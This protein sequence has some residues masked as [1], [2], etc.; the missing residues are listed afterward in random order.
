MAKKGQKHRKYTVEERE[1]IT[2]EYVSGKNQGYLSKKY[3]ISIGT[4]KTWKRKYRRDGHTIPNKK[5][6]PK[7]SHLSEIERLRLENDILKKFQVFLKAQQE[8]K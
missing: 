1:T 6:R 5:G 2:K 4:L 3:S 7:T 8:K